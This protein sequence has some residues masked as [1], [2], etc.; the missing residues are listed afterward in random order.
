MKI[1]KQYNVKMPEKVMTYLINGDDS[2]L[3][4]EDIK[5]I[6]S[7]MLEEERESE[8]VIVCIVGSTPKMNQPCYLTQYSADVLALNEL[9]ITVRSLD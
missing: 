2:G 8:S 6:V 7:Y 1:Y 3:N 9:A 4:D 5:A